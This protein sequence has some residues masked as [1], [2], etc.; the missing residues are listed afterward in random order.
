LTGR[1]GLLVLTDQS[2]E[3]AEA[4]VLQHG[5][6]GDAPQPVEG[7]V[8]HAPALVPDL[9]SPVREVH[10]LDPLADRRLRELGRIDHEEDVVV[11]E[12]DRSH[13]QR[14]L[15]APALKGCFRSGV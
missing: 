3:A 7:P 5:R 9:Q 10:D 12:R 8:G 13:V 4:L 6:L 14:R 2:E 1:L 15:T 11:L